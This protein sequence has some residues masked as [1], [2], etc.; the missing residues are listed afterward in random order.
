V[1]GVRAYQRLWLGLGVSLQD[2]SLLSPW[3][4]L[5]IVALPGGGSDAAGSAGEAG[6]GSSAG[7]HADVGSGVMSGGQRV[8][9]VLESHG[10]A[11]V[12]AQGLSSNAEK[13]CGRE[14]S[15][16]VQERLPFSLTRHARAASI[17]SGDGS[18]VLAIVD[19]ARLLLLTPHPW[20]WP[21][22][23]SGGH[24]EKLAEGH[25]HAPLLRA[26]D[27]NSVG[28]AGSEGGVKGLLE[29]EIARGSGGRTLER[30]VATWGLLR[31]V[32]LSSS[33][34]SGVQG[35]NVEDAGDA[36]RA[37]EARE[38]E[39]ETETE[40]A[41]HYGSVVG[42]VGWVADGS[43]IVGESAGGLLLLAAGLYRPFP[44][45][46]MAQEVFTR[47]VFVRQERAR[48]WVAGGGSCDLS[49]ARLSVCREYGYMMYFR[50]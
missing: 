7:G 26:V 46:H 36:G 15:W 20:S 30:F 42:T 16:H 28:S 47:R 39:T 18:Q 38:A 12:P 6:A 34:S 48:A 50:V 23:G 13:G 27:G 11:E 22:A 43:V 8:A 1:K 21:A 35:W 10:F 45:R 49:H 5:L 19:Q 41:R 2:I 31:D 3:Q 17:L 44:K 9:F 37:G 24:G 29:G 25:L 40:K 4:M 14:E 33:P 32:T